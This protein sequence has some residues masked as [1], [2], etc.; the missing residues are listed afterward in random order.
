MEKPKHIGIVGT[1]VNKAELAAQLAKEGHDKVLI[2]TPDEMAAANRDNLFENF[3]REFKITAPPMMEYANVKRF[4]CKGK[5]QYIEKDG[6]WVC[7]CGRV[8]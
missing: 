8:L 2:M 4:V 7:Q 1:G 3:H 6:A 5:H